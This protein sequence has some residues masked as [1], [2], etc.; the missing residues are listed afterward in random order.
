MFIIS[1]IRKHRKDMEKPLEFYSPKKIPSKELI[2]YDLVKRAALG[3]GLAVAKGRGHFIRAFG[4]PGT[5]KSVFGFDI[6]HRLN[7]DFDLG[8]SMLYIRCDDLATRTISTAKI[9]DE[10]QQRVRQSRMNL[11]SITVFDEIDSLTTPIAEAEARVARLTRWVRDYAE[12]CPERTFAIGVTNYPYRMDYSIFR[13]LGANLYFE[14]T[15]RP[16]VGDILKR[17]L[18]IEKCKEIG[19]RLC[20]ELEKDDFVPMGS[21]VVHACEVLKRLHQDIEKLPPEKLCEDLI[22]HTGGVPRQFTEDY[23]TKYR[24]LIN[25]AKSQMQWW[26]EQV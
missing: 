1:D 17:F 2:G 23:E 6:A 11:P 21:D 5:G 18:K 9:I 14:P 26:A 3:I 19:E 16:M 4:F 8:Y 10:L 15:P 24:S 7:A 22:A 20:Q 13:R 25:R 12:N